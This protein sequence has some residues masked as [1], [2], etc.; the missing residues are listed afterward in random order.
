[1]F[2]FFFKLHVL[3]D[4]VAFRSIEAAAVAVLRAKGCIYHLYGRLLR[5]FQRCNSFFSGFVCR[6]PLCAL[7][8]AQRPV[9]M[10]TLNLLLLVAVLL[11]L[12]SSLCSCL[13]VAPPRPVSPSSRT[14][15]SFVTNCSVFSTINQINESKACSL[16]YT[17]INLNSFQ[18]R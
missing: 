15:S 9:F 5:S 13:F 14:G 16:Q 1:M 12:Q 6:V 3:S 7:A 17:A 11:I 2:E 8:C 18:K 10:Q 4:P